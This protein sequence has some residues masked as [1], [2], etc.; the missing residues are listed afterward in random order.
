MRQN[1]GGKKMDNE[2]TEDEDDFFTGRVFVKDG[3]IEALPNDV[4]II[5]LPEDLSAEKA[6]PYC[7]NAKIVTLRVTPHKNIIDE[8]GHTWTPQNGRCVSCLKPFM[9]FINEVGEHYILGDKFYLPKP[10]ND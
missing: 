10:D 3:E 4:V 5:M 8:E 6:C 9:M 7:G 2:Q 1:K